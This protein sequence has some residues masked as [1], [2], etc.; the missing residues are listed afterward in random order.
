L[1]DVQ[2]LGTLPDEPIS[3]TYLLEASGELA[4]GPAYGRVPL[5][6]LTLREAEAAIEKQLKKVLR[7]PKV[8]VSL[9]GWKS[10]QEKTTEAR[11]RIR[12][13]EEE[14]QRLKTIIQSLGGSP[15]S[16]PATPS[17]SGVPPSW[18]PR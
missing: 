2:V 1:L 3:G 13:L 16:I 8:S 14:V 7:E 17:P 11:L 6:G 10:D 4:L 9:A 15:R 12:D 5:Q 18:E